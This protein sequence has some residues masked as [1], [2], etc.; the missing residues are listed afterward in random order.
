MS[1]TIHETLN[2]RG[3]E[4]MFVRSSKHVWALTVGI[5]AVSMLLTGSVPIQAQGAGQPVTAPEVPA[6]AIQDKDAESLLRGPL[7]EAIAE[8][9][10]FDPQPG[11]VVPKK[12]PEPIEEMPPEIKPEGEA[13][14]IPGY[15]AWDDEREDFLWVSGA[16]RVPPPQRRWVPGYWC[17]VPDGYQWISGFWAPLEVDQVQYLPQPPEAIER[18]PS[19]PPPSDNHFWVNGC[20]EYHD[21]RYVWRSGYWALGDD[22]WVW[23]P[24]HYVW[25]PQGCIYVRGYRDRRIVDRGLCFAPVYFR[26]S[27]YTR[28][29]YYYRPYHLIDLAQLQLHLFVRPSYC[30]Y[31]YGDWYG[32]YERRGIYASFNFHGR[33]G[34]DPLWTYNRWHY[35]RQGIDYDDRVRDWYR[36]FERHQDRRPPRTWDEQQRFAERNRGFE[37]LE[38]VLLG[39]DVREVASKRPQTVERIGEDVRQAMRDNARSL[40]NLADVRR[41]GEQ[42]E[43]R[44]DAKRAPAAG[45]EKPQLR[46]P[47]TPD[48]RALRE[49]T[50]E[51]VR[52]PDAERAEGDRVPGRSRIPS[53]ERADRDA[54]PRERLPKAKERQPGTERPRTSAEPRLPR[55][56]SDELPPPSIKP[57]EP[58]KELRKPAKELREPVKELREP[59][60]EPREPAKELRKPAKELRKPAKELREPAK[61][62][63]PGP[64]QELRRPADEPR[65]GSPE[66]PRA[67]AAKR[68]Q[69]AG[70]GSSKGGGRSDNRGPSRGPEKK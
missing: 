36:Y 56:P 43:G 9:V 28:P 30:H 39:N 47:E 54:D 5:L 66:V 32:P 6:T 25:T 52:T 55:D 16:Y 40:R 48:V 7:H 53:E 18:G 50:P 64:A 67:S 44:G 42:L 10:T 33:Y 51:G 68:Q 35:A 49:R 37:H 14:W 26:S 27:I 2:A 19:S 3:D 60:K 21:N 13:I 15:W 17:D 46:L 31:Y 24:A 22:D 69:D 1:A 65:R 41:N 45:V 62:S 8:P 12:P 38:Q 23:V 29:G 34:Y 20:W 59:A 11:L 58:A 57:R 70:R 63:R 61:E 4:D